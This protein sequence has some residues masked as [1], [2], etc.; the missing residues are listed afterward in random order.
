VTLEL[1]VAENM[2]WH[3]VLHVLLE[4]VPLPVR[5]SYGLMVTPLGTPSLHSAG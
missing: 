1:R 3:E 2:N 4:R 5:I